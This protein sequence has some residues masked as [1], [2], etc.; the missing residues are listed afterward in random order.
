MIIFNFLYLSV[1]F[2]ILMVS[3]AF[4]QTLIENRPFDYGLVTINSNAGA[5]SMTVATNGTITTNPTY[6]TVFQDGVPARFTITGLEASTAY[7]INIPDTT[8]LYDG[9]GP[10]FFDV[11]NMTISPSSFVTDSNG[12][13]TFLVGSTLRTSG[14]GSGY[15]QGTYTGSVLVTVNN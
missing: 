9:S 4:S 14:N 7:S 1:V 3:S 5:Y 13:G 15:P 8:M 6:I 11:I 10:Q 12:D 2:T